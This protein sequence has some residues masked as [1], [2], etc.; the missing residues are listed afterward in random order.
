MF[1]LDT[2]TRPGQRPMASA[3]TQ[4]EARCCS[5]TCPPGGPLPLSEVRGDVTS[6][7]CFDP[8]PDRGLRQCGAPTSPTDKRTAS[9]RFIVSWATTQEKGHEVPRAWRRAHPMAP[10]PLL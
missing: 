6:I 3:C 1:S 5:S 7:L 2:H 8:P 4:P 9:H 10:H